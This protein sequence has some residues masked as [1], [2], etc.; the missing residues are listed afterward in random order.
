MYESNA[1]S[2]VGMHIRRLFVEA[3]GRRSSGGPCLTM[4]MHTTH[5]ASGSSGHVASMEASLDIIIRKMR[6]GESM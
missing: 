1:W 6:E 3:V 2:M 4:A 5:N